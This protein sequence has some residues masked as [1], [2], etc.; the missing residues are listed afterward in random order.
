MQ[1]A[2]FSSYNHW[3]L[4]TFVSLHSCYYISD[5][6]TMMDML[7][8]S[9]LLENYIM[10]TEITIKQ[11]LTNKETDKQGLIQWKNDFLMKTSPA[12]CRKQ[13]PEDDSNGRLQSFSLLKSNNNQRK[14]R[15]IHEKSRVNYSTLNFD[16]SESL[17]LVMWL[18]WLVEIFSVAKSSIIYAGFSFIGSGP[19]LD[20]G[21]D[22]SL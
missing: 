14:W 4:P 18:L 8:C 9:D 13:H 19:G 6:C 15:P 3:W 16:Q 20:P 21:I 10:W 7:Y 5:H 1:H 17:N 22:S 2:C 11:T 12:L